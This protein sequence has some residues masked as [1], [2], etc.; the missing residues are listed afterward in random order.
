MAYRVVV[1]ARRSIWPD[2]PVRQLYTIVNF[3]PPVRVYEFGRRTCVQNKVTQQV[4]TRP[5]I[6]AELLEVLK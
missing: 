5:R 4:P 3:I 2:G 6:T 1:P